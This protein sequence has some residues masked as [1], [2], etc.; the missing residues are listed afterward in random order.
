MAYL[1][2]LVMLAH[3]GAW[4]RAN[5]QSPEAR[6]LRAATEHI[7]AEWS[8][9][10]HSVQ[11]SVD[12]RILS[13]EGPGIPFGGASEHSPAVLSY[14]AVPGTST[15]VSRERAIEC[16]GRP[17]V[18][19]RTNGVAAF[20]TFSAPTVDGNSAVVTA[21]IR[22]SRTAT[23]SDSAQVR[24]V[25]SPAIAQRRLDNLGSATHVKLVLRLIE[26][27]SWRVV[28]QTILGQS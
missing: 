17:K 19:C 27:S 12:P 3:V 16:D 1:T 20:V 26:G 5:A 13:V 8:K 22:T 11:L 7:H 4:S 9:H 28:S 6:V 2:L 15:I 25:R 14:A 18:E 21:F 24:S 23:A 10:G